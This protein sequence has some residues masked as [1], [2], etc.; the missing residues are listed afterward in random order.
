MICTKD[1]HAPRETV[2]LTV[3]AEDYR[4]VDGA[5][6]E[7]R[8][9]P[10]IER[11]E[12]VADAEIGALLDE[13]VRARGRGGFVKR[14]RR[15]IADLV[16]TLRHLPLPHTKPY[17]EGYARGRL[18]RGGHGADCGCRKPQLLSGREERTP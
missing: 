8:C 4:S 6:W 5:P 11:W 2:K 1:R 13:I 7:R 17:L 12:Y 15:L 9:G 3:G 18:I 14:T 10:F 16:G